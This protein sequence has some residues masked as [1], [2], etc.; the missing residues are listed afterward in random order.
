M[1]RMMRIGRYRR[2]IRTNATH[3]LDREHS[4]QRAQSPSRR[5]QRQVNTRLLCTA[6][7]HR[8]I[9]ALVARMVDSE[10]QCCITPPEPSTP[11]NEV[12]EGY[13]SSE[14]PMPTSRRSSVAQSRPRTNYRRSSD[15]KSTGACVSKDVR[16]RRERDHRRIRSSEKSS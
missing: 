8:D 13:S 15:Y 14:E 4:P 6:S 1:A 9:A 10:D 2:S 12:D 5:A 11:S 3:S 16:F 7:H